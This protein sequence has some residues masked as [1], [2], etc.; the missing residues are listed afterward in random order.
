MDIATILSSAAKL[1]ATEARVEIGEPSVLIVRGEV[2]TLFASTVKAGDFE[3]GIIQRLDVFAREQLRSTGKYKWQFME[4]GI[5]TIHAEVEPT[6][7]R[8]LLP[9]IPEPRPVERS[10]ANETP[11]ESKPGLFEK[12]FGRK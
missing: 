6:R 11:G 5:G 1:K 12:L 2:R 3:V 7:A 9:A 4:K 8:L 10:S